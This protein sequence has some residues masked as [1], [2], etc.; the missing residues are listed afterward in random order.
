MRHAGITILL[1]LL[2]TACGDGGIDSFE[3]GVEAQAEVMREMVSVLEGVDDQAS[4]DKAAG[5]IEALGT[6]L[7]DISVQLSEMPRPSAEE[8]Q[9]MAQKQSQ[10]QRKFQQEAAAQMMK[11]AEYESLADAWTRA[12]SNMR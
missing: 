7:M 3:D 8:M 6:R 5:E 9:A 4:A 2:C 1:A 12:M 11:L 10:A